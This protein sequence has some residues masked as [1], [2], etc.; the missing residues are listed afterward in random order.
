[1]V[2]WR[3]RKV[4]ETN[5]QNT[6]IW[7]L[8]NFSWKRKSPPPVA[9]C[10][11]RGQKGLASTHL[12]WALAALLLPPSVRP[13][14][15]LWSCILPPTHAPASF[16]PT[17]PGGRP[18]QKHQQDLQNSPPPPPPH[19]WGPA[20]QPGNQDRGILNI[21]LSTGQPVWNQDLLQKPVMAAYIPSVVPGLHIKVQSSPK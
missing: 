5:K 13:R 19:L 1:M 17:L 10:W 21:R 16:V 9:V 14:L 3:P 8:S 7:K 2:T 15:Q 12:L 6:L 18:G 11:L 4:L 20:K